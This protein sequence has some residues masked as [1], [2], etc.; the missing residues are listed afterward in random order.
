MKRKIEDLVLRAE[1][2]TPTALEFEEAR[3]LK[4]EEVIREYDL[5]DDVAK[6]DEDLVQLAESA[7]AIDSLKDLRYKVSCPQSLF[8]LVTICL[9]PY[10]LIL[11]RKNHKTQPCYLILFD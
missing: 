3:R 1:M 7:K 9:L 11:Q 2:L 4:Q 6:S 8:S 5:W 10:L